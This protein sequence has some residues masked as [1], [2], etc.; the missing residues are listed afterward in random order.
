MTAKTEGLTTEERYRRRQAFDRVRFGTHCV[1]CFPNDCPVYV[2]AKDGKV[3]F[4]EAAAVLGTVEPGVPDMNPLICQKGLAWSRQMDSPDRILHPLRRT[5]A[6]GEGRWER[7]SW[8][9]ALTETADA[10]LDAIAEVG[11]E[12][13][14]HE[15]TPEIVATIPAVRFMDAL[16]ATVL[17]VDATINDFWAGTQAVFGKFTFS[18]SIDDFFHSDVLLIWHANPAYT[19]IPAFH[20]LVEARYKGATLVLISPDVSPSHSHVDYH[21]PV[22]HGTDA[23][24]ALAMCQ[25]VLAEGLADLRFASEQ[26]DLSLLVRKDDGTYLRESDVHAGGRADRFYQWHPERGALPADA[27]R[28]GLDFEPVL[29]GE[30]PV[31]LATGETLRVEPLLARVRR[32]LDAHYTPEAAAAVCEAHP[33]TIRMLARKVAG[34][35]TRIVLGAG[36]AKYFHGDLMTRAMLLLLGLTANW[37]KKGTGVG[38]WCS[39]MFDGHGA[40]LAKTKPG[41]EGARELFAGLRAMTGALQAQDPTLTPELADRALWR[42]VGA[43]RGMLPPAF[44]WY[45][46][47][48][49]RERWSRPEWSD[50]TMTRPFEAYWKEAI[51]SGGWSQLAAPAPDRPP[52]V[53]LEI[54]GNTLRRTRGGK[55]VLL[56]HLWPQ[57][58]KIVA[59]D[60]RM[61]ETALHADIVL[62]ATQH[63]E[64]VAFNM[65]TP[66]TMLLTMSDAAVPPPG[67]AR[68]EWEVLADLCAKLAERALARG[69]EQYRD[70]R[71]L[72]HRFDDLWSRFTLGGVFASEE[73]A[74]VEMVADAVEVGN[75]PAGTTL[76]TFREQ[77]YVRYASWGFLALATAQASPFP[78]GETHAPLRDHVERGHPYPT[79]SRRAQFLIDHPWFREAGEDLPAHKEPPAMGGVH[80]FRLS[81]GHARWSVHAMNMTN[82]VILETHRGRPFVLINSGDAA[83]RGIGDDALVRVWNDVGEFTVPARTSPAQRPGALTVYNGF[84][85]FM[86]PGGRGHNEVEPGLVKWLHLVA[87]YGHLSYTP[88][89]W[90]PVPFDRCIP[91]DIEPIEEESR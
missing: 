76:A 60:Y 74:A 31:A 3:V 73:S 20:Y 78:Q 79:L 26:T 87:N 61:S 8:D 28:L 62:P 53:L 67:E 59:M 9:E 5:G 70:R 64:K 21:V 19:M 49:F 40:A 83:A 37:G 38:G 39:S 48:G 33:D 65:P 51:E 23:A 10:I 84:E 44:Y 30:L 16:G 90:Q 18:A 36:V 46:H 72:V 12:A 45:W 13:V 86:F 58:T 82:P 77:G 52:R 2:F 25:V 32:E 47:A 17:D 88:V 89:E 66:W 34:G 29:S 7:I 22:R 27:G 1:N 80:P 6:R 57:L 50:P 4:E 35:R 41:R 71:G 54:A 63:H 68:S 81:G 91:V 11:P 43:V 75:L 69:M 15:S 24:L 14:V 42:M 55:G 85:G 56:E